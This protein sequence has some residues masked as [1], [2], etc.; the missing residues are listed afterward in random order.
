MTQLL[1]ACYAF[2]VMTIC[3]NAYNDKIQY[4]I[5]DGTNDGTQD[6]LLIIS[7]MYMFAFIFF[8]SSLQ[9]QTYLN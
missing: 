6:I 4:G 2:Y 8:V 9:N 1:M 3:F 7:S 5:C